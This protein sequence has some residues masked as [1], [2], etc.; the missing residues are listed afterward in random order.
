MAATSVVVP[1]MKRIGVDP[2]MHGERSSYDDTER[3]NSQRIPECHRSSLAN[4]TLLGH[5]SA[6]KYSK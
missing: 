3:C 2:K 5:G 1:V 4:K 6:R